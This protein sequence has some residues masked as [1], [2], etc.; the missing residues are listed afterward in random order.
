MKKIVFLSLVIALIIGSCAQETVKFPQGAW[1]NVSF[2]SVSKDSL[3]NMVTTNYDI[4]VVKMWSEK[5]FSFVG[6]WKQDTIIRD[7]YGGGT[8]TLEG[9]RYYENVVYHFT[10]PGKVMNY[11]LKGLLEL[12]N[13]TLI[14]TS[15]VD[16]NGRIDENRHSVE[17]YIRLK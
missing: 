11:N 4:D 6:Q 13:D 9:N 7:F 1:K 2:Q 5:N 8:Y 12:R 14:Q 10:Q 16:D 3:G 15:P 17:K